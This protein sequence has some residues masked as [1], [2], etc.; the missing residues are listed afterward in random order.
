MRVMTVEIERREWIFK[1]N[2]NKLRILESLRL[3]LTENNRM[4]EIRETGS[5]LV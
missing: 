5:G 2:D 3:G 1:N 4:S